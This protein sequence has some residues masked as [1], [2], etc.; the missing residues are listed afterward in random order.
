MKHIHKGQEPQALTQWKRKKRKKRKNPKGN[1]DDLKKSER[2]AIRES[3]VSEQYYLCAYCCGAIDGTE[4]NS[5]NEHIQPQSKHPNLSLDYKNIVA[6]CNKSH[7]GK[8]KEN[9]I[10]PLTPLMSECETELSFKINGEVE[11]KTDRAKTTIDVLQLGNRGLIE[12]RKRRIEDMI[13]DMIKDMID[14]MTDYKVSAK[15]NKVKIIKNQDPEILELWLE[16]WIED[17]KK[18]DTNKKLNTFSPVLV[19]VLQRFFFKK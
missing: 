18:P 3:C 10:I 17:L 5:H 1:Y 8:A 6:S 9:K 12:R 13:K 16:L 2:R 11:G 4:E 19:N 15:G 14:D 7:C